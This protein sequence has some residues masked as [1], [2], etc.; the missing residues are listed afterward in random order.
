VFGFEAR[1][2]R[3][4]DIRKGRSNKEDE[5]MEFRP[6][7]LAFFWPL[8]TLFARY[9][10]LDML[11]AYIMIINPKSL[12]ANVKVIFERLL[13]NFKNIQHPIPNYDQ[14]FSDFLIPSLDIQNCERSESNS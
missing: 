10:S 14:N 12:P 1:A 6:D 3:V 7:G 9:I 11:L 5:Y 13:R 4:L 8:I 2:L